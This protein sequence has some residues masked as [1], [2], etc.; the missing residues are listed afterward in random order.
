LTSAA[1]CDVIPAVITRVV[2]TEE[3]P[4]VLAWA[5]RRPGWT[6]ELDEPALH[7]NITTSH[8]AVGTPLRVRADLHGYRAVAPAWQFLSPESVGTSTSP[9]PQP[10]N[11]PVIQ[12]S[13]F[14]GN[15]VI[16]A[17]WNRLAYKENGG[18]HGDWGALTNWTEA[19]DGYTKADT[20]ADMLSQI[21]L[22]LSTSPGMY[23]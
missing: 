20:L 16:C 15:R 7:L 8:P 23:P 9:F 10:G 18:P 22:H 14:H 2:V 19:A 12:G 4:A 1:V 3:L 6:V 13:I 21:E 11:H 17:P 5:A